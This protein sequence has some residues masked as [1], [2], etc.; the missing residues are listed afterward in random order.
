MRYSF[1]M[2]AVEEK[3]SS[4][5]RR[6][7]VASSRMFSIMLQHLKNLRAPKKGNE[8]FCNRFSGALKTSI[9]VKYFYTQQM[10]TATIFFIFLF[11]C[12]S[13]RLIELSPTQSNRMPDASVLRVLLTRG[14]IIEENM[15]IVM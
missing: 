3:K 1:I 4:A 8:S 7:L 11:V 15:K 12:L 13:E 5:V 2:R 9:Y 6:L 14:N 10:T